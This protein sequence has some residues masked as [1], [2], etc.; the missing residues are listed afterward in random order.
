[1]RYF[2]FLILPPLLSFTQVKICVEPD[3]LGYSRKHQVNFHHLRLYLNFHPKKQMVEG[4]VTLCFTPLRA[5]VDSIWLDG[6]RVD[7][8]NVRLRNFIYC[9]MENT[10]TTIFNS[11][12]FT[13]SCILTEPTTC[14][15]T[16]RNGASVVFEI[17][18]PP[19]LARFRLLFLRV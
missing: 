13:D 16:P 15:S 1:M 7:F 3:M 6:K 18:S 5:Q 10:T 2:S 14:I 19:L 17:W 12:F 11:A 4:K 9:A 8:L